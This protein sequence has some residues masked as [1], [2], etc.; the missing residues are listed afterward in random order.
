MTRLGRLTHQLNYK[1]PLFLNKALEVPIIREEKEQ[2]IREWL[3]KEF[4]A[5][6]VRR[7]SK[8]LKGPN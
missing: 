5:E 3:E 7:L 1:E 4:K 8:Y 2:Q 6:D